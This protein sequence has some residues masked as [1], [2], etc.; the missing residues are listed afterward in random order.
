[1]AP[2]SGVH[3]Q[4]NGYFVVNSS[5]DEQ[6]IVSITLIESSMIIFYCTCV[7]VAIYWHCPDRQYCD[8]CMSE[9]DQQ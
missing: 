1:M 2:H 8:Q 6:F 3:G 7:H 4:S 9:G 5:G